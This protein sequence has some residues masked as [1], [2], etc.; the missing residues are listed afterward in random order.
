MSNSKCERETVDLSGTDL[1]KRVKYLS[2]LTYRFWKK[3]H[4][5]YLLSLREQHRGSLSV[6]KETSFNIGVVVCVHDE[7]RSRGK[8]RLARVHE[9]IRS[10]DGKIRAAVIR[11]EGDSK[12]PTYIRRPVQKLFSLKLRN[13]HT[14][15]DEKEDGRPRRKSAIV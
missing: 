8:W 15:K 9:L 11:I 1:T 12:K 6:T 7:N 4:K 5:E 14:Q 13:E 3:W 2:K 10:A